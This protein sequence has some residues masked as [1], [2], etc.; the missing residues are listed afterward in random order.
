[1][2]SVRRT[3]CFASSAVASVFPPGRTPARHHHPRWSVGHLLLA[4]LGA[5]HLPDEPRR[6]GEDRGDDCER[7]Q[8]LPPRF[9]LPGRC[10]LLR[11]LRV[12]RR[13]VGRGRCR[14]LRDA[15]FERRRRSAE[16]RR[17]LRNVAAVAQLN[18]NFGGLALWWRVPRQAERRISRRRQVGLERQLLRM[19]TVDLH[20]AVDL[21]GLVREVPSTIASSCFEPSS[22]RCTSLIAT[23]AVGVPLMVIET[24]NDAFAIPGPADF[25]PRRRPRS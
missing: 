13:R 10:G 8:A 22:T 25:R 21:R 7:Q 14:D 16:R 23:C 3:S 9:R 12:G 2:I 18:R 11:R 4:V 15:R 19:L 1:M 5:P 6:G 24:G 17:P 20:G